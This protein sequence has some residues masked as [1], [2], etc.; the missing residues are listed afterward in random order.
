MFDQEPMS[1]QEQRVSTRTGSFR[2]VLRYLIAIAAIV[3][4]VAMVTGTWDDTGAATGELPMRIF[5]VGWAISVVVI[6][7]GFA[8]AGLVPRHGRPVPRSMLPLAV[9]HVA[10]GLVIGL[11]IGTTD[12]TSLRLAGWWQLWWTVPLLLVYARVLIALRGPHRTW[13]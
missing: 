3:V 4:A 7:A 5:L 11:A 13:R 8:F 9:Q 2:A 12:W 10:V 1:D 6:S